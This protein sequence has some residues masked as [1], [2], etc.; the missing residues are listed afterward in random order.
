MKRRLPVFHEVGPRRVPLGPTRHSDSALL[1]ASGFSLLCR[2]L[3]GFLLR[4]LLSCL[5]LSSYCH[6]CLLLQLSNSIQPLRQSDVEH[7]S[8]RLGCSTYKIIESHLLESQQKDERKMQE[9]T[10]ANSQCTLDDGH[11]TVV[12]TLRE[13]YQRCRN[14]RRPGYFAR[15]PRSSSMRSKRLYLAVLSLRDSDPVLI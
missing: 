2:L 5:L 8:R 11:A 7:G 12:H 14:A 15:L 13:V 6:I 1:F 10:S 3:C 4:C 9:R